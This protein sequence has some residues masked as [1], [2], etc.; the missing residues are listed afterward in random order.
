M[1][2]RYELVMPWRTPPLSLNQRMHH[3]ARARVVRD[4]RDTAGWLARAARIPRA[5]RVRVE[6]R[7]TPRA[8]RRRDA[9]NL[10]ALLKPLVDALVDAGVVA[11]D[12]DEH[13]ERTMPVITAPSRTAVPL[14]LVV[15]VLAAA[16]EARP[17]GH[18]EARLYRPPA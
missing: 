6:L 11:D 17:I 3:Y 14:V 5:E 13:V 4:V 16:T 18:R 7:Y 15:E 12:D 8:R 10:V 9:D 1:T 2:A